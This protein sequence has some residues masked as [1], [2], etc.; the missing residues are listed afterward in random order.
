MSKLNSLIAKASDSSFYR[1][2]L[3]IAFS[4]AVPFNAPH[5]FKITSIATGST[6]VKLPYR[7]S[8]LNHVKGIHACA[9]AT[10][11][12]YTSGI[13]MVTMFSEK[14]YRMILKSLHMDYHYQARMDVTA[15]FEITRE[16]INENVL[17]PLTN[18]DSV[19]LNLEIKVFDTD[20]N[21]ICTC[22]ANW[23]V[24]KWNK[25]KIK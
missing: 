16:F 19:F 20:K 9:L 14:D 4:R 1:W 21:H 2:M 15:K 22:Q 13:T 5:R 8:N 18:Q 10:L 7:R 24:K 25:V 12:E 23:Q 3:N 6:E 17:I 11:C